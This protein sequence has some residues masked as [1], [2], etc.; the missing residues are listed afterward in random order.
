MSWQ[1]MRRQESTQGFYSIPPDKS[2]TQAAGTGKKNGSGDS[3][4][5]RQHRISGVADS[6]LADGRNST[7]TGDGLGRAAIL[8]IW[9]TLWHRAY[10]GDCYLAS[11][12]SRTCPPG[13]GGRAAFAPGRH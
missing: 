10:E 8:R 3:N 5:R 6:V 4:N 7:D 2:L 13:S 11:R 9:P 12:K 1:L